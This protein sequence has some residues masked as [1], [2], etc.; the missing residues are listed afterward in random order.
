M[1][2]LLA[3]LMAAPIGR[4]APPEKISVVYCV[5]CVPF[6][7]RDRDGRAAGMI[8]DMWREWSKITGIAIEFRAAPWN[9]TLRMMRA[10][11]ADA[12]AGLFFNQER[13]QYLEYGA[14][15]AKT[16]THVFFKKGTP[17]IKNIQDLSA[18]RV[19][20]IAGDFVEGFL[21][22]KLPDGTIVGFESYEAIVKAL[23]SGTLNVFAADTPTGI[24]HLQRAELGY[25]FEFEADKPLYRNDWL[26]AAADGSIELVNTIN[27]G[28]LKISVAEKQSIVDRWVGLDTKEF[29]LTTREI[30]GLLAFLVIVLVFG[31]LVWNRVLSRRIGSR[32]AELETELTERKAAEAALA[33]AEAQLRMA[34]DHMSGGIIMVGKDFKLKVFNDNFAAIYE[35]PEELIYKDAPFAEIIK[36]RAERGDYGPGDRDEL[37]QRRIE[38]YHDLDAD[39]AEDRVPSGRIIGLRRAKT[40]DG[41]VVAVF[42]DITERKKAE[43]ERNLQTAL[44]NSVLAGAGQGIAAYDKDVILLACNDRYREFLDLPAALVEPGKSGRDI[45]VFL[46]ERGGYGEGD[47][48]DI[49][50]ARLAA[51]TS[52]EPVNSEIVSPAGYVLHVVSEPVADGGFV[53]TYTDITERKR[54]EEALRQSEHD[55]RAILDSSPLGVTVTTRTPTKD[56]GERLYTNKR[57]AELIGAESV[58]ALVGLTSEGLWVDPE[59]EKRL[60]TERLSRSQHMMAEV[61]RRRLDGAIWWSQYNSYPIIF[62]GTEG[63]I[64]WND[65]ITE[66]K[67]AEDALAKKEAQ[68]RVALDN[69]PG[70]MRLT[71]KDRNYVFFNSQYLELY[72]FPI[73]LFD[74]GDSIFVENLYQAER[75]ISA[76]ATPRS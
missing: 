75:G 71:D 54:A 60:L 2:G 50:E 5:D 63:W 74:V 19:G 68:L 70:G 25:A 44:L 65:D 40:E 29:E 11:E 67:E 34:L 31:V 72:D 7:F 32:T 28:M 47:V 55:L 37:V 43:E 1:F 61:R 52:G 27:A 18:Y 51:L 66:R 76:T 4:A 46:A 3:I 45:V 30:V 42:D 15:L 8:I 59:D 9:E 13:N 35:L 33:Q 56:Y 17:P 57:Y 69:M 41:D 49:V 73:D 62:E 38:S 24:Y 14:V 23:R 36:A 20:V 58:D 26:I 22:E 48:A 12:H 16:D 21:K 10:R 53:L 6:Q 64:N 39:W